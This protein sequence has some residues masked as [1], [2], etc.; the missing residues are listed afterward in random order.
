MI[1]NC[2]EFYFAN[3]ILNQKKKKKG[4]FIALFLSFFFFFLTDDCFI[5]CFLFSVKTQHESDI[6]IHISH[7]YLLVCFSNLKAVVISANYTLQSPR[8]F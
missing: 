4:I 8:D 1:H 3:Y 6:G 2:E 7:F 5:E